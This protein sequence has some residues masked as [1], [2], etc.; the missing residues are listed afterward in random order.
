MG[1][2]QNSSS[3]KDLKL[4]ISFESSLV[5][6]YFRNALRKWVVIGIASHENGKDPNSRTEREIFSIQQP[7]ASYT[8]TLKLFPNVIT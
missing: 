3:S 4:A 5:K 2:K 1:I 6:L 7:S 8:Y